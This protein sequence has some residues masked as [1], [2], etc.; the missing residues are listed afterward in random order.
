MKPWQEYQQQAA[1]FFRSLGMTATID[2][3]VKGVRGGHDVDVVARKTFGGIPQ[4]W[5][6]ECKHWE[7]PVNQ[8]HV[9]A[10]AD[11]V[12]NLGADRGILLSE[13]GFQAGAVELAKQR[14]ITLSS[15]S[16]LKEHSEDERVALGLYELRNRVN[17]LRL[18][19]TALRGSVYYEDSVLYSEGWGVAGVDRREL[20][21]LAGTAASISFAVNEAFQ[22]N[23]VHVPWTGPY[24]GD[25]GWSSR[26]I[27]PRLGELLVHLENEVAKQEAA[28]QS[29][30]E[31]GARDESR[32]SP[33][34][35]ETRIRPH[36]A[37]PSYQ[38]RESRLR[39]FRADRNL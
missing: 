26:S 21:K 2:E 3:H 17:N 15:I 38:T 35:W 18:R 11:I 6:V 1:D 13:S 30:K 23:S 14:N 34:G 20:P 39:R 12:A 16:Y 36:D 29:A 8:L 31:S 27:V 32:I 25:R 19:I 10:L 33:Y 24:Q 22:G 9:S 37:R 4:L 7:R 28:A 5:I